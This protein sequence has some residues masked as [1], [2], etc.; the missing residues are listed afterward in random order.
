MLLWDRPQQQLAWGM[1]ALKFRSCTQVPRWAQ[2]SEQLIPAPAGAGGSAPD[3]HTFRDISL[4]CKPVAHRSGRKRRHQLVHLAAKR[5]SCA[6][7]EGFARMQ[8]LP[9]IRGSRAC[10]ICPHGVCYRVL[11][12]LGQGLPF[13]LAFGTLH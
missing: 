4:L 7:H 6:E 10:I 3:C 5:K 1:K 8:F 13:P 9:I 11:S 2:G 12:A